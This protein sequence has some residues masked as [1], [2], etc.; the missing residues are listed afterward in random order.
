MI[1]GSRER[2]SGV[3]AL[4]AIPVGIVGGAVVAALAGVLSAAVVLDL[5]AWWPVWFV[6]GAVAYRSRGRY[7]GLIR[8]SGLVP[9][10]GV[11]ATVV[12]LVAHVQGWALMPSSSTR[13]IGPEPGF[14]RA[15]LSA[16]IDGW[17]RIEGDAEFLYEAF[18]IRW[19]G[20]VALP[21][22][23][24][25]TVEGTISVTL[26]PDDGGVFQS[27]R[28]WDISL[29]PTPL[30]EL[31]LGGTLE[32]DLRGLRLTAVGLSG[33]GRV[34]FGQPL[35]ATDIDVSGDFTLIF[36]ASAP[37]RVIGQ[38]SVPPGWSAGPDGW[39]S[40][41]AGAGWVVKVASGATVV[42]GVEG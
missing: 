6:L 37:V 5:I 22:A 3:P 36:P 26:Q 20:P 11:L 28:G 2:R 9:L 12:F 21:T 19:G 33:G 30:W 34:G 39:S 25:R 17:L 14:E 16:Q 4:W 41:G 8:A 15:S 10:L 7:I 31:A 42:V 38:A 35:R 1:P 18:P 23:T 40:P 32:A 29:S 27:F 13:L 24:E